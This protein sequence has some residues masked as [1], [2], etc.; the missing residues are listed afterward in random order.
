MS[1]SEEVLAPRGGAA[2]RSVLTTTT[3]VCLI[4]A[5]GTTAL[6]SNEWFSSRP[7]AKLVR[8]NTAEGIVSVTLDP[9]KAQGDAEKQKLGELVNYMHGHLMTLNVDFDDETSTDDDLKEFI[10]EGRKMLA[11]TSSRVCYGENA[12]AVAHEVWSCIASLLN[13]G[14]PDSGLLVAMPTFL[15]DSKNYVIDEVVNPL[16]HIGIQSHLFEAK[17]FRVAKGAPFPGFRLLYK[18]SDAPSDMAS[19]ASL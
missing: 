3:V 10:A 6:V 15:G 14:T 8:E 17:S 9:L 13:D 5:R 19:L 11:I 12:D 16:L 2:R 4:L 1:K 18:P 7:V